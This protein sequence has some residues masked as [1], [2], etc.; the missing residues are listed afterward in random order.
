LRLYQAQCFPYDWREVAVLTEEDVVDSILKR[1]NG[2]W[3][4]FCSSHDA[5]TLRLFSSDKLMSGWK[6]HPKSP[7]VRS[8]RAIGRLGGG[9]FEYQGS[10]YRVAQDCLARYGDKIRLIKITKL[11]EKDYAEQEVSEKALLEAGDV[12]WADVGIHQ[13]DVHPMDTSSNRWLAVIDGHGPVQP[14]IYLD[15]DFDNGARLGGISVR[16][17]EAVPGGTYMLSFYWDMPT[18]MT[19]APQLFV[20]FKNGRRD[21]FQRDHVVHSGNHPA[22]TVY[23]RIP[24]NAVPGTYKIWCGIYDPDTGKRS[25]VSSRFETGDHGTK[26]LLPASIRVLNPAGR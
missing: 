19:N 3:W 25:T 21:H 17:K 12:P 1:Y 23:G 16:P 11:S 26:L 13:F 18:G 2:R 6:E 5:R 8:N 9:I 7:V 15:A 14:E 4:L 22:Y 24:T 20:H 10:L